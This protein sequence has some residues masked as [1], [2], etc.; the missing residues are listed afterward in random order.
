MV[1]AVRSGG[2]LMSAEIMLA[3]PIRARHPLTTKPCEARHDRARTH[4]N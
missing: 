1:G 3:G 4:A 2:R